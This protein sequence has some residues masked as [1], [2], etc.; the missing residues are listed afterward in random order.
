MGVVGAVGGGDAFVEAGDGFF[1]A[2]LFGESL[3]GHL[4]GGDVA[5]IV[6]DEGGEF[7][8]SAGGVAV[9]EVFHGEAVAGEGV[10]GVE[11]EDF[12]KGSDLVHE[13]MVRCG[14]SSWQV[15]WAPGTFAGI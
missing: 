10:G 3:R 9:A 4:V 11:L 5:R 2:T 14:R 7:G 13:L 15:A 12:V 8:E 1:G 6:L